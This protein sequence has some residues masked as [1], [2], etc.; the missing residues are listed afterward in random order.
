MRWKF[1]KEIRSQ[2][3]IEIHIAISY[4]SYETV[5]YKQ[6]LT[7]T[8]QDFSLLVFTCHVWEWIRLEQ[9]HKEKSKD[10]VHIKCH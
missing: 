10:K 3:L 4:G 5:I 6:N 2:V 8:V 7:E 9:T 1:A